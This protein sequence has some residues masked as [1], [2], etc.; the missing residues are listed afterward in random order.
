MEIFTYLYTELSKSS[1]LE[2]FALVLSI[3]YVVLASKKSKWCWIF[4]I[5]SSTLY[6]VICF[7]F[8]LFFESIL[9]LFY[10]FVAIYGWI[11]WRK[12]EDIKIKT[13]K[14]I[15]HLKFI[16]LL[17]IISFSFGFFSSRISNQFYPYLDAAIFVFSIFSTFLLSKKVLENWI[18]F[19]IIDILATYVFW[20]RGLVLTSILYFLYSFIA[21]YGFFEWKK[22]YL[23][24]KN[25]IS[26]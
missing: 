7:Q 12:T 15:M 25:T 14:S 2:Y 20:K 18:Y 13:F 9:Q 17:A 8:Q 26:K 4:A 3:F 19:I 5:L 11:N 10:V 23:Q 6:I 21:I 1:L 24:Q 22:V 16:L